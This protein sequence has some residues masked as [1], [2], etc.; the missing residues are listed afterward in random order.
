MARPKRNQAKAEPQM[1][2]L[3][4]EFSEFR[5]QNNLSQKLL[6]EVI[7]ISRRTI[8]SIE[9]GTILPHRATLEAFNKLREK[10]KAEGKSP[11]RKKTQAA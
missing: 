2:Q 9:A 4:V 8:Q 6:A 10:Y 1:K 11:K 5:D 3:A 7:G